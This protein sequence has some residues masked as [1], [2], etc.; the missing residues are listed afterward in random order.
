[1]LNMNVSTMTKE[2]TLNQTG[3]DVKEMLQMALTLW[4]RSDASHEKYFIYKTSKLWSTQ[5]TLSKHTIQN[6]WKNNAILAFIVSSVS[7]SEAGR[8][9]PL[10]VEPESSSQTQPV[11][12]S[13]VWD[14][15]LSH[16]WTEI[17]GQSSD[18]VMHIHG[19][20]R[21]TETWKNTGVYKN[22]TA[23]CVWGYLGCRG[24]RCSPKSP[25][26]IIYNYVVL[27]VFFWASSRLS[28]VNR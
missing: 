22:T 23:E 4:L 7:L 10:P 17:I 2:R 3:I 11:S 26:L 28:W 21:R 5:T 6:A 24:V 14:E 8:C 13:S 15:I 16:S 25:I 27:T 20:K 19:A 9:F 12:F 18:C 1:M